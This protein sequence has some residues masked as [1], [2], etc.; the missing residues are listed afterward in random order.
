MGD[1]FKEINKILIFTQIKLRLYTSSRL[2]NNGD[3][4]FRF[5]MQ[6]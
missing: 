4:F 6:N 1:I 5:Y 3:A 2:S